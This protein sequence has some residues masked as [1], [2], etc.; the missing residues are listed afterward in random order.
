M[1]SWF[2]DHH[3]FLPQVLW[4]NGGAS[5]VAEKVGFTPSDGQTSR[6]SEAQVNQ[7]MY[8]RKTGHLAFVASPI[9]MF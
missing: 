3:F 8:I 9:G 1:Q 5:A 4:L 7:W 6:E 2:S